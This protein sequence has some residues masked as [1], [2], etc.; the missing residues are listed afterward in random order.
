MSWDSGSGQIMWI[1][2]PSKKSVRSC[3]GSVE[4]HKRI[5]VS[6]GIYCTFPWYL[7]RGN[8]TLKGVKVIWEMLSW[9]LSDL[10]RRNV[11]DADVCVDFSNPCNLNFQII[12]VKSVDFLKF[13]TIPFE[14]DFKSNNPRIFVTDVLCLSTLA[15]WNINFCE[16]T[17]NKRFCL[18][19]IVWFKT[20]QQ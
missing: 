3:R 16:N 15:I 14:V 20:W 7:C 8:Q 11:W 13:I 17:T 10:W 4:A 6:G 19:G 2:D 12:F 1:S 5:S 9:N 18:F